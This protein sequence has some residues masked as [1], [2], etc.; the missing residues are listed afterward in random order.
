MKRLLPALAALLLLSSCQGWVQWDIGGCIRSG[1]AV[2][3]GADTHGPT[4]RYTKPGDKDAPVYELAPELLYHIKPKMVSWKLK[5]RTDH[6]RAELAHEQRPTGRR[7]LVRTDKESHVLELAEAVPPGYKAESLRGC[8][9]GNTPS[10]TRKLGMLDTP[11][12]T[13]GN[14]AVRAAALPFDLVIDP[15]LTAVSTVGAYTGF[16]CAGLILLPYVLINPDA[17]P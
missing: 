17:L 8:N 14:I 1:S 5:P 9:C 4:T 11:Q 2:F 16:A 7:V 15:A 12:A 3:V 6:E 10:S 13:R